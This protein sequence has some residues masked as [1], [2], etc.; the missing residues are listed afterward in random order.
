MD[1]ELLTME[2]RKS[3]ISKF[4]GDL[5][6]RY[7]EMFWKDKDKIE[8]I[9]RYRPLLLTEFGTRWEELDKRC[10]EFLDGQ[11]EW[12]GEMLQMEFTPVA[13]VPYPVLEMDRDVVNYGRDMFVW[14]VTQTKDL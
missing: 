6:D 3:K 1:D 7:N 10:K 14:F 13:K 4:I 2:E 12:D 11:I 9:K 8:R 5:S